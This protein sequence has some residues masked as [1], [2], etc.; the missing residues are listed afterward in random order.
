MLPFSQPI[1][2][3]VSLPPSSSITQPFIITISSSPFPALPSCH[4]FPP[5]KLQHNVYFYLPS[6]PVNPLSFAVLALLL[7]SNLALRRLT[8]CP[9]PPLLCILRFLFIFLSPPFSPSSTQP[10]LLAFLSHTPLFLSPRSLSR[11]L[12][13]S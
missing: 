13:F 8:L 12:F 7:P 3:R 9:F 2:Q 5:Y 1:Y 6:S 10:V 11:L 4:V